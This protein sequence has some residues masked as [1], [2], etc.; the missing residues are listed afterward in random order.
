MTRAL[1]SHLAEKGAGKR[2]GFR[3]RGEEISRVEGFS[4]AVFAFAITL[5]VVSLEV[6]RTFH[7]LATTMRGFLAFGVCFTLIVVLWHEHYTFFRRYG[8]QDAVTIWLNAALLFVMLFY[9]YPLKFVFT[10]VFSGITGTPSVV[11]LPGGGTEPTIEPLQIPTLFLIYGAGV[12]ALYTLLAL[13]YVHAYRQRRALALT[14]IEEFDT[15]SSIVGH[16][17]AA[18]VGVLSIVIALAV[19]TRFVGFAGF[20][21]FLFGP[22]MAI[23]GTTA[24]RLRRR[25]EGPAQT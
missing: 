2:D 25:L 14:P 3:W 23:H 22:V 6:P 13:L 12:I 4:D 15:K 10:L 16:L 19:P 21:Y 24:G 17:L 9:V 18:G 5:L 11:A 7:E 20:V 1:R 8:L